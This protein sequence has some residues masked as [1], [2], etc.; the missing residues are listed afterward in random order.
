LSEL[1]EARRRAATAA[2]DSSFYL[3]L[4]ARATSPSAFRQDSCQFF[5]QV[6]SH[7]PQHREERPAQ[8]HVVQVRPS[9]AP[10]ETRS[11]Y[12]CSPLSASGSSG[13]PAIDVAISSARVRS[14]GTGSRPVPTSFSVLLCRA[15]THCCF[16]ASVCGTTCPRRWAH[17]RCLVR[18]GR[19]SLART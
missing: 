11:L 12:G 5:E 10:S 16:S 3:F 15:S 14:G 18:R 1:C 2:S 7:K 6:V 9:R 17:A 4:P 19:L 8:N 13:A